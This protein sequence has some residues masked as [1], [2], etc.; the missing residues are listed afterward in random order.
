MNN[1]ALDLIFRNA[2][3][4]NAWLNKPVD[5]T[6]LQQV[7]DQRIKHLAMSSVKE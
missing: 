7:Y 5:D 6:L 4:H 3:T 1:E 2:R